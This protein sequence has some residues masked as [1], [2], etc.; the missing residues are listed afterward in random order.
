[1]GSTT[2][3]TITDAF[4]GPLDFFFENDIQVT[5]GTIYFFEPIVQSGDLWN[6]EAWEYNYPGGMAY[7]QGI[8]LPGSDLW[9]REG[10]IPEPAQ[11][12]LFAFAFL[13]IAVWRFR[14]RQI[15]AEG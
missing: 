5:P 2:Q 9:F 14:R 10:V 3:V 4:T 13:A 8:G 1:M 15:H 6:V 7:G 12:E 11:S